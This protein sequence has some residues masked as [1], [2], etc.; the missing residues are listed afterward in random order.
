VRWLATSMILVG[1]LWIGA[2]AWIYLSMSALSVPVSIQVVAIAYGGMLIPPIAVVVGS[3]LILRGIAM[4]KSAIVI[5][6]ACM[7][8]TGI[9]IYQLAPVVRPDPL[10]ARAPYLFYGLL[11]LFVLLIDLGAVK[12]YWLTSKAE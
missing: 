4:R 12:L 2:V 7:L 3:C 11:M 9:L 8:L 6:V 5:G 10:Q 1:F